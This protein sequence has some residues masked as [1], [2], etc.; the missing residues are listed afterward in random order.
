MTCV[1]V[2]ADAFSGKSGGYCV[3]RAKP[4]RKVWTNSLLPLWIERSSS[5]LTVDFVT[6]GLEAYFTLDKKN[7][8]VQDTLFL[9]SPFWQFWLRKISDGFAHT[10]HYFLQCI[11]FSSLFYFFA[12]NVEYNCLNQ[13]LCFTVFENHRKSLIQH[14]ERRSELRLHFEWTKVN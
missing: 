6:E 9:Q 13:S 7:C 1:K 4:R 8:H 11:S 10:L 3:G 12:K 2:T 5:D 14:C